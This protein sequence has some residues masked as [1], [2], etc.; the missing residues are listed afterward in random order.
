MPPSKVI[1]AIQ[2]LMRIHGAAGFADFSPMQQYWRDANVAA[3]HAAL[4]CHIGYEIFGKSLL[5]YRN[6]FLRRCDRRAQTRARPAVTSS[7]LPSC[8]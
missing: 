2:T 8:S 4:N 6:G 5:A 1:N 3:R 7:R